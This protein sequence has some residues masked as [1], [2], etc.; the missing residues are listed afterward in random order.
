M[1]R[2]NLISIIFSSVNNLDPKYSNYY[3]SD[4]VKSNVVYPY[5]RGY[6]RV[7]DGKKMFSY[8]PHAN[9]SLEK[10][11]ER[12]SNIEIAYWD[13]AILNDFL[14]LQLYKSFII[15]ETYT[16]SIDLL[17]D[18]L[19]E[20]Q[21]DVFFKSDLIFRES[22]YMEDDLFVLSKMN[23]E[24]PIVRKKGEKTNVFYP[25][26]EKII[27]DVLFDR[28]FDFLDVGQKDEVVQQ[29][30]SV[31][32]VN[33]TTLY[34]YARSRGKKEEIIAKLKL[35]HLFFDEGAFHD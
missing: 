15:F 28:L 11:L 6:Y 26:I 22:S 10:K 9:A 29:A 25:K 8:E 13:I 14:S 31:Y 12:F 35:L 16:F 3:I 21:K 4:L 24:N 23:E 7:N 1:S 18:R 2:K 19:R 5:Y 17:E 30:F 20:V 33:L 27:V 34:R 32:E